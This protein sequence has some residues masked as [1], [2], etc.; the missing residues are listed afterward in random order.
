MRR[1]IF[2]LVCLTVQC[3]LALSQ[4]SKPV[5]L[6]NPFIGTAKSD[7]PTR[8]GNEGGTYPG[9]V[10]PFGFIQLSPETSIAEPFGYN[11][12]DSTVYFFSCI[13]HFSGYPS[14]S[15]G[16][17]AVMPI[18]H[19]ENFKFRQY[20]S[21]FSHWNEF[22]EPGYYRVGFSD[23]KIIVEA[24][25]TERSGMFRITF[26][27]GAKPQLFIGDVGAISFKSDKLLFGNQHHTVFEFSD[28]IQNLIAVEGGYI[29][30]FQPSFDSKIITLKLST[31]EV[32]FESAQNNL[33]TELNSLSFDQIRKQTS[34]KWNKELSVIEVEDSCLRNKTIFYTALYH[35]FLLPWII[36][37]TDGNYRGK[38]SYIYK[39]KGACQYAG[40]SPWDTFRSLHPLLSLLTPDKQSDMVQSIIDVYLQTG[41]LPIAP[42][43]GN[44]T[45]PVIVDSY[46]KGILKTDSTLLYKAMEQSIIKQP[47]LQNDLEIYQRQGYVPSTY[48]ESVTCTVEYA[49]DDWALAQ[50]AKSFPEKEIERKQLIE[51][52]LNY[53]NLF[54]VSERFLL[55]RN[56]NNFIINPATFGYKEGDKWI[57]SFFVPQNPKD[58]VNLMGG[59]HEF[60]SL[61]DSAF[62]NNFIVFDNETTF[63]IPYLFNYANAPQLTQERVQSI[64]QNRFKNTPGGIPG[65]DDLGSMSSW[66]IWSSM[67]IYPVCP[68]RLDYDISSPIFRKVIIHLK[69]NKQLSI[70]SPLS[71][72]THCYVNG[73]KVNGNNYQQLRIPHS[74]IA[75]GGNLEFQ[76]GTKPNNSWLRTQHTEGS[77]QINENVDIEVTSSSVSKQR[78]LPNEPFQVRF[79]LTNHGALGTK[80]VRLYLDDKE[81]DRKNCL[82]APGETKKDSIICR[83]FPVGFARLEIGDQ[84]K[85][86]VEVVPPMNNVNNQW[87]I[88]DLKLQ[89]L[90]KKGQNL[91]YS[92]SVQNIGGYSDSTFLRTYLNDIQEKEEKLVLDAGKKKTFSSGLPITKDGLQSFGIE[93]LRKQFKAYTQNEDACILSISTK[94]EG[95]DSILVDQSGLNNNAK[96]IDA[97]KTTHTSN[98]GWVKLGKDCYVEVENPMVD[99]S[100]T[101]SLTMMLWIN[102]DKE[103]KGL[104]DIFTK[105]DFNVI[106]LSGNESLSFFAGGWGRGSCTIELPPDWINNWHHVAG[107]CDGKSLKLYLDGNLKASVE[108]NDRAELSS[109]GHWIVGRNE[110]FPISR[111]FNGYA[112][113][114]KVFTTPLNEQEIKKIV[115]QEQALFNELK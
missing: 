108:L 115:I 31:S 6:V 28:A 51:R 82:V 58:L 15:S 32:S 47:F 2:L 107:V 101:E 96:I 62:R 8:W 70:E 102:P 42:M 44:H 80:I 81:Y 92:F 103:N 17:T 71:G 54:N 109:S 45:V 14:G 63:H 38:D 90:V 46:L 40:F 75:N 95:I 113:K 10:A 65:N 66:Y 35:S 99:G 52:S 87:N 114:V 25:S 26:P 112:D 93:K 91:P 56:K 100:F 79:S 68:G 23:D 57:Y 48:P 33:K 69:N 110:E 98:N 77:S 78:V 3:S 16:E 74:T 88:D 76:L 104:T 61:L 27:T 106:Q 86:E 89:Q 5:S 30:S 53:R 37:D 24:T 22:A 67:G 13:N 84:S 83:L 7:V 9:S 43:T 73:L 85:L 64:L 21:R 4:S 12:N 49:Y 55:P 1:F 50:F 72:A 105:G 41:H 97:V 20:K 34:E 19:S 111:I 39:T 11:Y 36:S 94:I 29:L 18:V 59:D 60:S